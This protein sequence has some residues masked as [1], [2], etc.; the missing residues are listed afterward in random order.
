MLSTKLCD[1]NKYIESLEERTQLLSDELSRVLTHRTSGDDLRKLLSKL[2][3]DQQDQLAQF[4]RSSIAS[5]RPAATDWMPMPRPRTDEVPVRDEAGPKKVQ[6][7]VGQS[8]EPG[9]TRGKEN[10][11]GAGTPL[12]FT[13]LRQA[14]P[15]TFA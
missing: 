9:G 3:H 1:A 12:W 8:L 10:M 13:K 14:A 15:S 5:A 4:K 7:W 11:T 2:Q 6:P